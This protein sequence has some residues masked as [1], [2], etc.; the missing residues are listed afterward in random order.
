MGEVTKWDN[1]QTALIKSACG[2]AM[3]PLEFEAFAQYCQSNGLNPLT[4]DI[5]PVR[6]GGKDPRVVYIVSIT[7]HLKMAERTG[8]FRGFEPGTLIVRDKQTKELIE[9][10]LR[11]FD[12]ERHILIR[13]VARV[14][15]ADWDAPQEYTADLS[16][17]QRD[18][19]FWKGGLAANMLY[20]CAQAV[21]L[22]RTFTDEGSSSIV[23][24]PEEMQQA[25]PVIT[26]KQEPPKQL[27]E[28]ATDKWAKIMEYYRGKGLTEEGEEY[29][30]LQACKEFDVGRIEEIEDAKALAEWARTKLMGDLIKEHFIQ[31]KEK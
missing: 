16:F 7:G 27:Q 12:D 18:N 17:Y 3:N 29:A 6:Y 31:P 9:I 28:T 11:L 24:A 10:P 23:Y 8:K 13:A 4:G 19:D 26:I 14:R 1:R 30:A 25:E 15:H 5:R 2:I 21:A 22:R 20:K